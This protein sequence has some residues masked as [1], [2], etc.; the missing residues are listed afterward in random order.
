MR[1][2]GKEKRLIDAL[3]ISVGEPQLERCLESVR[4]QTLPFNKITHLDSVIPESEGFKR[5]IN[6]I[7]NEWVMKI[8]GDMILNK[9]AVEIATKTIEEN[10]NN[11][12]CGYY[13][14]LHDTFLNVDMGFCGALRTKL[15]QS[16][17]EKRRDRLSEDRETINELRKLGWIAKKLLRKGVIIGTHFDNPDEFQVFRRFY[18]SGVRANDN[19]FEINQMTKLLEETKNPLYSLAIEAIKFAKKKNRYY[20]GS[21]NLDFDRQLFGEFKNRREN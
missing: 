7:Q 12:V 14:G 11:H 20:I 1:G 5:G 15:Y 19:T 8:D 21:R 10:G 2:S 4:K 13:F 17:S 18:C 3:V 6:M 16:V 9:N